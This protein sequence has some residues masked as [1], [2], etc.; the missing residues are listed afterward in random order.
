MVKV[1]DEVLLDLHEDRKSLEQYVKLSTAIDFYSKRKVSLGFCAD[2]AELSKED[3][4]KALGSNGISIF[5]FESE[6]DFIK[7]LANA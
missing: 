5:S 3:F 4:I 7:E 6:E 2:I 1:P